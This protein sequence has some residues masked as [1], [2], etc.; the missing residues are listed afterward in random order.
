[1]GFDGR[2]DML[3]RLRLESSL[4]E[5]PGSRLSVRLLA[6]NLLRNGADCGISRCARRIARRPAI[7][8]LPRPQAHQAKDP[9]NFAGGQI[10][11][12][13]IHAEIRSWPANGLFLKTGRE[14]KWDGEST[15]PAS[16]ACSA[17]C[18]S[19][20]VG[21]SRGGWMTAMNGRSKRRPHPRLDRGR[22]S[23][24]PNR[25]PAGSV[26]KEIKHRGGPRP[27]CVQIC[28]PGCRV[29]PR[30]ISQMKFGESE[31]DIHAIQRPGGQADKM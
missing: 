1:M 9:R 7:S 28:H 12:Q 19:S 17:I 18:I 30:Q 10:F 27:V 3:L 22:R 8:L 6:C 23:E 24:P 4:F 31:N 11:S 29:W 15:K 14:Q 25:F 2:P 20:A 16:A 21:A 5:F 26:L 13:A